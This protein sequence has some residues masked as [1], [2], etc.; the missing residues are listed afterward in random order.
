MLDAIKE[1]IHELGKGLVAG[2]ILLLILII[3]AIATF[4]GCSA[5]L[6]PIDNKRKAD[7][8]VN[9]LNKIHED[10]Q[11]QRKQNQQSK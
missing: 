8:F 7:T 9:E 3:F 1:A 10:A 4:K 2:A 6:D 5:A 11:Q